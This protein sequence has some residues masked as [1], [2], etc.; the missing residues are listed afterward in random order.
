MG[1]RT[2]VIGAS[3][4]PARYSNRAILALRSNQHE[5]VA[6][7]KRKG[8]VEDVVIETTFPTGEDVHTVT[9]YVGPQ[10]QPGYYT[11]ILKLKPQRVI[12]NPGTENPEFAVM[13]EANGIK[14]EEACTLVLL[15]IGN[16]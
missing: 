11:D 16:Y 10:H 7:A 6:L 4:N 12:F 3:E 9:L 13:L 8:L 5:V 14:A 2:L 15:S 1:K